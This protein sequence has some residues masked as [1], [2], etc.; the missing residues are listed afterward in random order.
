MI[1]SEYLGLGT[2]YDLER[3][4]ELANALHY[5]GST[6][7]RL[8]KWEELK[9][10]HPSGW[11]GAKG[12]LWTDNATDASVTAKRMNLETGEFIECNQRFHYEQKGLLRLMCDEVFSNHNFEIITVSGIQFMVLPFSEMGYSTVD[13]LNELLS[14]IEYRGF[15][16][17]RRPGI[18]E[19]EELL[20]VGRDFKSIREGWYWTSSEGGKYNAYKVN[21]YTRE[22]YSCK[23]A[24]D[25]SESKAFSLAIVE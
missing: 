10:M 24:S 2:F 22:K 20:P 3:F 6:K 21:F 5:K 7:W 1:D 18:L 19:M 4:C 15:T 12:E 17:Y 8:P 13:E 16:N 9:K 11:N 25:Y 14:L 23:K